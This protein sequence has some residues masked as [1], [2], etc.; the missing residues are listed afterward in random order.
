MMISQKEQML[1]GNYYYA[2]D[3]ELVR[4]R[5]CAKSLTFEFN[6]TRPNEKVV[7]VGNPCKVIRK[8]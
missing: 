7:A 5:D 8:I 1:S 2:N 4:E 3:E 6:Y